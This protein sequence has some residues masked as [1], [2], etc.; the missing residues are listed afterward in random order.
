MGH[1]HATSIASSSSSLTITNSYFSGSGD[2]SAS[3]STGAS[4]GGLVDR[5]DETLSITNSYFRGSAKISASSA[6]SNS[7]GL[8][9]LSESNSILT[10]TNSYFAGSGGLVGLVR[11]PPTMPSVP[12]T[13][14]ITNSYWN[15]DVVSGVGN[16]MTNLSNVVG[17]TLTQLKG[18]SG[19]YPNGLLS[20]AWDLG[21]NTQ[22]PAVKLC[23]PTI[24]GS[25]ATAIT[26]WT[27]CASHGALLAGQR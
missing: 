23:V 21:T 26:D 17:L 5:S 24:T 11:P 12:P 8:V 1:S 22:L 10:I 9:G 19:T 4:S 6:S 20:D 2:I 7:G 16:V 15:T 14:R 13:V 18:I 27:T 25:G 3:S